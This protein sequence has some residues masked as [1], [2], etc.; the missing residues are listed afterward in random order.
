VVSRRPPYCDAPVP[1]GLREVKA[2]WARS[3]MIAVGRPVSRLPD[4]PLLVQHAMRGVRCGIDQRKTS[5][6]LRAIAPAQCVPH[7]RAAGQTGIRAGLVATRR[8]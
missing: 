3:A 8:L 5:H 4:L 2:D 1:F 6:A 7:L